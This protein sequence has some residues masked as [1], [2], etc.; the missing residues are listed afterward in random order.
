MKDIINILDMTTREIDALIDMAEDIKAY[1]ERYSETCRGRTLATL[2]F[3]PSTRTRLSFE[4]A[5]YSLGGNCL[6]FSQENTSSVAKGESIADTARIVSIYSDIIVMRHYAEGAPYAAGLYATVPVINAGDGGHNHPTQTLTDLCTIKK[7]FGR[8]DR[9]TIG[10]CGDLKYGRTTH[11]LISAMLR[12][13]N[14]RLVLISPPSLSLP[15]YI[16]REPPAGRNVSFVETASL[17]E[18]MGELDVL[19]MTRIQKER[20]DQSE[21]SGAP[22]KYILTPEKLKGAKKE[23]CILHPLP[24]VDEISV[25][26]DSDPRAR[27]FEEAEHGKYIRMALILSLLSDTQTKKTPDCECPGGKKCVNKKCISYVESTLPQRVY[28]APDK[29]LRCCYCDA[30]VR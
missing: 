1:P 20:F 25:A 28:P 22:G 8:L 7:E 29:T 5:M 26:V 21:R 30:D 4:A 15:D 9:L 11:S 23:M 19:Y 17:D 24:R 10:I 2:F 12:Y 3:E 14:V 18:Y 13:D 16:K 6:G 27:Y